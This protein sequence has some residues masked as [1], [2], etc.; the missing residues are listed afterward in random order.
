MPKLVI[1]PPHGARRSDWA[2]KLAAALPEYTIATP[3]DETAAAQELPDADAV[4]G[5]VPPHLLD[6]APKLRWL[7]SPQIAPPAEFYY[8]E[9]IEHP[10][11]VTN[12]RGTFNDH[13]A[14]HILMYVIALARGLPYYM[15]AQR[16]RR[17]DTEAR[18][19]KYINLNEATALIVG[20]GGIGQE[21]ARLCHNVGMRVIGVDARWEY[22]TPH[23]ERHGP[24]DLDDLLPQVDFVI[25]TIPHTPETEGTWGKARFARMKPT[26][27]FINIGRGMTTKLEELTDA[28]EKGV[29]AGCGLD[30]FEIEPL[31]A[32][33]RLWTLP[34]VILTPHLAAKGGE[35]D[36]SARQ[37]EILV[38][39]ARRFAAG[40][41]LQNVVDKRVWY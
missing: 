12:P 31:P 33:H 38:N 25:L 21:A 15:D 19:S 11:T 5:W 4:F 23:V 28:V 6:K 34:N 16:A 40:E 36:I 8:P 2:E 26:G 10:V 29:I 20:V 35:E 14:Q 1:M 41:P 27:Y 39:N 32:D 30:V 37:F 3:A 7:Q 18:K 13:I 9:L 17:W 24:E 22:D